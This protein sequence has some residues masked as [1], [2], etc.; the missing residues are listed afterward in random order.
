MLR[1]LAKMFMRSVLRRR[2]LLHVDAL[3]G[4]AQALCGDGQLLQR[5]EHGQKRVEIP[6]M[7][8]VFQRQQ[9]PRVG[10]G[11]HR[12]DQA[13]QRGRHHVEAVEP[14]GAFPEEGRLP[15]AQN[16]GVEFGRAV[17]IAILDQR[18]VGL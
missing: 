17:L 9:Q 16:G 13:V 10:H 12:G 6:G 18:A 15:R 2:G 11:S 4:R 1:G 14:H 7:L 8:V 5:P 3:H